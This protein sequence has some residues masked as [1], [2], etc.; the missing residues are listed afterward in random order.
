MNI[1]VLP[2]HQCGKIHGLGLG[3]GLT[4]VL[5]NQWLRVGVGVNFST[6]QF[7]A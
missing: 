1:M 2:K 4:S 3:L 7:M 5:N 6:E